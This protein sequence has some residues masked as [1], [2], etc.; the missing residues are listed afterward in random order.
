M[1]VRVKTVHDVNGSQ[2]MLYADPRE[3]EARAKE[4]SARADK[5]LRASMAA[6]MA[7][8][9]TPR[10]TVSGS[11]NGAPSQAA[12]LGHQIANPWLREERERAQQS[13]AN[14]YQQSRADEQ[15]RLNTQQD[16]QRTALEQQFVNAARDAMLRQ[17]GMQQEAALAR[18]GMAK[19]GEQFDKTHTQRGEQFDRG[20][21]LQRSQMVQADD[22]FYRQMGFNEKRLGAQD[23]QFRLAHDASREDS[24]LDR[25]FKR[26][27]AGAEQRRQD[28]EALM[29]LQKLQAQRSATGLQE[30]S[31]AAQLLQQDD[32]W[33]DIR[34]GRASADTLQGLQDLLMMNPQLAGAVAQIMQDPALDAATHREWDYNLQRPVN[35]LG[36][37]AR[38]MFAY[39]SPLG[40]LGL[41]N[42]SGEK[43]QEAQQTLGK[44]RSLQSRPSAP[45]DPVAEMFRRLIL[46]Q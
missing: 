41:V 42:S 33:N 5:Q 27:L 10:V 24:N 38:D 34:S 26:D 32:R 7:A 6:Q 25:E 45:A 39:G 11:P 29:A 31:Q 20:L 28:L 19:Q 36:L 14:R 13:E 46:S 4:A 9:L 21:G 30:R 40:W 2:G 16:L 12:E 37:M 44:L 15:S 35:S 18:E 17:F 8:M 23:E 3:D 43:R 22:H 1:A